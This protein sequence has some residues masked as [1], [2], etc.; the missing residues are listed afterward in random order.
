MTSSRQV[1]TTEVKEQEIVCNHKPGDIWE[2]GCCTS[3]KGKQTGI[4]ESS[5]TNTFT[6]VEGVEHAVEA[7]KDANQS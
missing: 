5:S 3:K 1:P 4:E 2:D 6:A 7:G